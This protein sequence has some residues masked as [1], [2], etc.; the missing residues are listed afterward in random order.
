[1]LARGLDSTQIDM[2]RHAIDVSVCDP[3][4]DSNLTEVRKALASS[5]AGPTLGETRKHTRFA[6]KVAEA[7]LLAPDWM[8]DV[9]FHPMGSDLNGAWAPSSLRILDVTAAL[10]SLST[11]EPKVRIKRRSVQ[12]VSR[13]ISVEC[14]PHPRA[15]AATLP[16]PGPTWALIGVAR[17]LFL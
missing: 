5:S 1:V 15:T 16:Q 9:T 7:Q 3:T 6:A 2:A 4:G 17:I 12:V 8:P 10:S 13:T 14:E 11:T